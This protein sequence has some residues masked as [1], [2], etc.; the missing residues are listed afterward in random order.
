VAIGTLAEIDGETEIRLGH[1][2]EVNLGTAPV[3]VGRLNTPTGI[4]SIRTAEEKEVLSLSVDRQ[5]VTLRV[6]T[7]DPSEPTLVWVG[8]S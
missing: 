3:F 5:R 7:N 1:D 4:A 8:V 2:N 6:W